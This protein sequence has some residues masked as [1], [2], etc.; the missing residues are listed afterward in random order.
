MST[1]FQQLTSSMPQGKDLE[2]EV[3]ILLSNF[4]PARLSDTILCQAYHVVYDEWEFLQE[5]PNHWFVAI[6][7]NRSQ[8]R[9][10]ASIVRARREVDDRVPE[11]SLD[12]PTYLDPAWSQEEW[13]DYLAQRVNTALAGTYGQEVLEKMQEP[14]ELREQVAWLLTN[15]PETRSSD[16]QLILQWFQIWG[17]WRKGG[18]ED[19]KRK[20]AI[21]K[22]YHWQT[23]TPESI[24]AARRKWHQQG[25]FLPDEGTQAER[26]KLE[27]K[28]RQAF[29]TGQDAWEV[30]N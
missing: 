2:R 29:R 30:L 1:K 4:A 20:Y 23:T 27:Q 15:H 3:L 25:L 13:E 22:A 8:E 21:P 11:P 16:K 18:C 24:T 26:K 9:S 6:P 19:G 17:G 12:L 5:G 14:K 10:D 28:A 7:E